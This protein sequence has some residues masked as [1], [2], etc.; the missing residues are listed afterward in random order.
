MAK[1]TEAAQEQAPAAAAATEEASWDPMRFL[2]STLVDLDDND[3]AD[4]GPL[5]PL[6]RKV[7]GRRHKVSSSVLE[8][9]SQKGCCR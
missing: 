4:A 5:M 7:R 2:P 9:L 1:G 3:G 8:I 6:D